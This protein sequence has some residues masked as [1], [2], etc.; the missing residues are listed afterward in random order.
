METVQLRARE[1]CG[2]RYHEVSS[3]AACAVKIDIGTNAATGLGG[4]EGVA[5]GSDRSFRR[6]R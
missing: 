4:I 6:S 1:C 5:Q 3:S 2:Y